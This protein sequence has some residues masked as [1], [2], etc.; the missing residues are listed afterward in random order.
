MLVHILR[1]HEDGRRPQAGGGGGSE[2]DFTKKDQMTGG[3]VLLVVAET[4]KLKQGMRVGSWEK[5]WGWGWGWDCGGRGSKCGS[6]NAQFW[7]T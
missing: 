2:D 3:G 6:E 4:K 5:G 1:N 7:I